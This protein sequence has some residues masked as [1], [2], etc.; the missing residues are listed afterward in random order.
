[1]E[2]GFFEAFLLMPEYRKINEYMTGNKVSNKNV[3][4]VTMLFFLGLQY[5][6]L[7]THIHY[8]TQNL[9]SFWSGL[10]NSFLFA[11]CQIHL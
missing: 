10:P 9:S 8:L 4:L 6:G 11:K 5:V 3:S 1:M 2:K 7:H